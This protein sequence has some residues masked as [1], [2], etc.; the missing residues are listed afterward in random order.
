VIDDADLLAL[1]KAEL[2]VHLEGTIAPET[3]VALAR[4]HGEL[5]DRVLPLVDGGYPTRYDT[6]DQFVELYLAVSAQVRTPDDLS[7]VAA[8]FARQQADQG[9]R[10]S[11]ATFTA[12]THVSN[13]M[14]PHAMWQAV[15]DGFAEVPETR[16]GLIVDAVRN[17]GT[18]NGHDTV[19]LVEEAGDAPVVAFGLAGTETAA[20]C[21]DFPMLRPAADRLGIGLVV[22]AGEIGAAAEVTDALD[23]LRA[24][25][26]AH[27]VAAAADPAVLTRV[28]EDRVPLD[29]CPTSNV[30][31]GVFDDHTAHPLPTLWAAGAQ[32]TIS[33]D[34]PP[35]FATTLLDELRH[36]ERLAGLTRA[37]LALLQRRAFSV[38]FLSEQQRAAL[39]ADLDAW[40][41]AG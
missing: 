34:D 10:Y 7:V 23:T 38:A 24:D 33:S 19:R 2:H 29:V 40:V 18:A 25:R 39:L 22:H 16:V 41:G 35:F 17:F 28:V 14:E 1:P 15:V 5:P 36:A 32:V 12:T 27:G 21:A 9:V 26:I 3:A 6:F 30:V 8:A 37:D 31:L 13:G 20:P 4:A 11:E